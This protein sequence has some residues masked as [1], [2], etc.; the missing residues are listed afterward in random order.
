[1]WVMVAAAVT[2]ASLRAVQGHLFSH[3]FLGHVAEELGMMLH[4]LEYLTKL[5][6]LRSVDA[7]SY[8]TMFTNLC[9]RGHVA[10]EVSK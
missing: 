5:R 7:Q 2:S 9:L 4:Q 6:F 3:F 1:M 10:S 8:K